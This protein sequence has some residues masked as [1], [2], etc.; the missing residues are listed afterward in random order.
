M[1]EHKGFKKGGE[2][3]LVK[4]LADAKA[5]VLNAIRSGVTIPAAMAL[6]NKKPDTIRQWMNRDPLFAANLEEAKI[7]GQKQSFDAMGVEKESMPFKDFSKAFLDQTVFPHHQDWV[8]LLEGR[9][10]SWLHPSMKYEPG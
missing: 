3:H 1:S 7:E 5:Q 4:G 6:V 9:E 8:D 10:P 2:H